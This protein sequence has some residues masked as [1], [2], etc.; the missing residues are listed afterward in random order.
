MNEITTA[1]LTAAARLT[2][3]PVVAVTIDHSLATAWEAMRERR[4]HHVAVLD[5]AGFAAVLD[6]RSVAA[7]WPSGGP[8][9]PH[10]RRVGDAVRREVRCVL[11]DTPAAEVAQV[12]VDAC[13]DAVPVVTSTGVLVGLV[14][15]TDLVAAVAAGAVV[16]GSLAG[17]GQEVGD[18]G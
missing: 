14:T 2:S 1:E 18:R 17:A 6:D 15:S 13:C 3:T 8:D 12:M 4:L 7:E 16:A 11:P 10:R 5:G 9:A